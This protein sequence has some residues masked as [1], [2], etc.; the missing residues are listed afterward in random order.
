[1]K[2]LLPILLVVFTQVLFAQHK[3]V[4]NENNTVINN[5]TNDFIANYYMAT[6]M[7]LSQKS[8]DSKN[9]SDSFVFGTISSNA[10]FSHL[11]DKVNSLE[12]DGFVIS[13]K[14]GNTLVSAKTNAGVANGIYQLLRELGVGLD[15]GAQFYPSKLSD[16]KDGTHSSALKIRG[17][18]PWYNF[19]NSPTTWNEI[20]H[21]A[22]IDDTIRIGGNFIGFHTYDDEP[23]AAFEQGDKLIWGKRLLS[24]S[25]GIWGTHPMKAKDY[26]F[27]ISKLY[28]QEYFGA[29]TTEIADKNKAIIAEQKILTDAFAYAKE[30]GVKTCIGFEVSKNPLE[31]NEILEFSKRLRH[32]LDTYPTADYIW[33]WQPENWGA[34]GFNPSE[35]QKGIHSTV[36]ANYGKY[37][38]ETFD[39]VVNIK[40]L[41]RNDRN[42][43]ATKRKERAEEGA[44]LEQ[45]AIIAHNILREYKNA[46]KL[47]ISGWGGDNRLISAEYYEGLDILLPKDIIFSSLDLIAPVPSVDKIYSEL[48][49][50]RERWP[51]P[52]LE[53][54]GD[55]WQPQPYVKIYE[56]LMNNLLDGKSQGVVGIH[57]RTRCIAENFRY[58]SDRAWNTDLS[59]DDFYNNYAKS[60]YGDENLEAMVKIHKALDS[61]TAYRWLGGRGQ[62][63]CA[64]FGWGN[65]GEEKLLNKI[66][67]IKEQLESLEFKNPYAKENANWLLSRINWTLAYRA[68]QADAVKAQELI[69]N[70]DFEAAKEVL[71]SENFPK[72]LQAYVL[73][74]TTRG[75]YGVLPTIVTKAYYDWLE[76]Y[77]KVCTALNVPV[78]LP[79]QI[80]ENAPQAIILPRHY[81]TVEKGSDIE[82]EPITLGNKDIYLYYKKLGD[83]E[84]KTKKVKSN[85]DFWVKSVSIDA[86]EIGDKGIIFAFD[87]SDKKTK[88]FAFTPKVIAVTAAPEKYAREKIEFKFPNKNIDLKVETKTDFPAF[89]TWNKIENATY[90][91]VYANDVLLGTTPLEFLPDATPAAEVTYKVEAIYQDNVVATSKSVFHKMPDI[92][93]E[94]KPEVVLTS[95]TLPAVRIDISKPNNANVISCAI[96]R[97]KTGSNEELI[98]TFPI[99]GI[100]IL[101]FVD[102]VDFGEYTYRFAFIN[103]NGT[104]SKNSSSVKIT[105]KHNTRKIL[106]NESLT[107]MSENMKSESLPAFTADGAKF[108]ENYLDFPKMLIPFTSSFG[109][110]LDFVWTGNIPMP[111]ILGNGIHGQRGFYVQI[112]NK[113]LCVG[114][115]FGVE[116]LKYVVKENTPYNLK[117]YFTGAEFLFYMNDEYIGSYK[118]KSPMTE[119]KNPIRLGNYIS[120]D[121]GKNVHN[122][123][124]TIKNLKIFNL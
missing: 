51:I 53:N 67:E 120:F 83:K 123:T 15:L 42:L 64:P 58:L 82:F 3:Y 19:L 48:P 26:G 29:R 41:G 86:D 92:A 115:S 69:K 30:R 91:K 7:L 79:H 40:D 66:L 27:G 6:N 97:T 103:Y 118:L 89:L 18:L 75:E 60:L 46:P 87:F 119:T 31:E 96:Y 49:A 28:N 36:L 107:S 11:K 20:D 68:M 102:K 93:I 111:I 109:F 76:M 72:A 105:H 77:K 44:R 84:W 16:A 104:E 10:A 8:F 39:R 9:F 78:E 81:A 114:G 22:F 12:N 55:Q 1:M 4:A 23:F 43:I 65:I 25:S 14:D 62:V 17:F 101:T 47:V 33:L 34:P 61:E 100:S 80:W 56:G 108:A 57:W 112:M 35:A 32:I 73:R 110:E 99:N 59:Y 21:R 106:L 52:W 5:A 88:D 85:D 98:S 71:E 95:L 117:M 45:Y 121:A 90:Y 63:E 24:T 13:K 74:M 94:E 54:D 50:D 116:S 122:F 38:A 113:T 124:G 37:R 70:E 2:K